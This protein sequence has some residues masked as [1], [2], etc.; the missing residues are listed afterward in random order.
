[1]SERKI[2]PGTEDYLKSIYLLSKE[3]EKIKT[4]DIA[5]FM[6]IKA[7]SASEKL[8]Q[9]KEKG[10]V[11][12]EKYGDVTITEKGKKV[13]EKIIER[14]SDLKKFFKLLGVGQE[15]AETDA[16]KIEHALSQETME[17]LRELLESV[18]EK[19]NL[20]KV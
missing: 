7:P 14:H 2:S 10:F 16:C 12:H 8:E 15:H 6:E 9:L 17:K 3:K 20:E 13:A 1:M 5:S 11:E 18:D 19:E 4:S